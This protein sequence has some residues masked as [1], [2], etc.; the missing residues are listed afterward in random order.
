MKLFL[1]A[2]HM[3]KQRKVSLILLMGEIIISS[4]LFVG[5]LG[6]LVYLWKSADIANTFKNTNSYYFTPFTYY[7]PDFQLHEC[8][9]NAQKDAVKIGEVRD[10]FL[11]LKS[12]EYV[13]V[14]AYNP[15][16]LSNINI[17]MESGMWITSED[18]SVSPIQLVAIG[19]RYQVGNEITFSNGVQGYVIGTI[20]E[21]SYLIRMM[22]SASNGKASLGSFVSQ[23]TDIDFII[24]YSDQCQYFEEDEI[25]HHSKVIE[26]TDS[27]MENE[28]VDTLKKYG[29]ISSIYEMEQNFKQ[30][31]REYFI[32]NG[33]LLFVFSFLTIVGIFGTNGI[34]YI[35]NQKNYTIYYMLGLSNQKCRIL[36][37]I[38]TFLVIGLSYFVFLVL[39]ELFFKKYLLLQAR[40][41]KLW[42]L[43]SLFFYYIAIYGLTSVVFIKK[44]GKNDIMDLY[45]RGN[46]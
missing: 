9:D 22:N 17:E 44:A 32:V 26:I 40:E 25:L 35:K 30:N 46:E 45:K 7:S 37:A 23:A 31:N 19:N 34:W 21:D 42:I 27:T 4:L 28:I 3:A 20:R 38:N 16:I 29:N 1:V 18:N 8:L 24:P 13:A 6:E 43:I 41:W 2:Y 33:I 14:L 11:K 39:Y 12:G 36:E 5:I 15:L 10:L